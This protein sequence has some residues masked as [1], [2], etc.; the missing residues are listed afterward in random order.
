MCIS[1]VLDGTG[2]HHNSHTSTNGLGWQ[3]AFKGATHDAI[4]TMLPTHLA[5]IDL[6]FTR[7]VLGDKG[8]T[9]AQIPDGIVPAVTALDF[10]QTNIAILCAQGTLVAENGTVYM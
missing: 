3:I 2:V 10:D 7:L 8:H 1:S 6:E 5:P 4:A 9:F